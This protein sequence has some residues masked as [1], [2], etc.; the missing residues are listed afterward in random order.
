MNAFPPN[1]LVAVIGAGTM[2]T[3]TAQMAAQAGHP[4][5]LARAR[6][7]TVVS[8]LLPAT[9][10]IVTASLHCCAARSTGQ[11]FHT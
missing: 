9:V 11:R 1:S 10:K 3:G 4:V 5:L 7:S 2:G 6:P 8:A